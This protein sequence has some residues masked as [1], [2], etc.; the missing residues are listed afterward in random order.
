MAIGPVNPVLGGRDAG[1]CGVCWEPNQWA[2]DSM[3]DSL[4]K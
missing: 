3:R 4:Q 1:C 2:P